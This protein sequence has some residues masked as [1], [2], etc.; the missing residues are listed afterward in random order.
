MVR[1]LGET[2]RMPQSAGLLIG[3]RP[4]TLPLPVLAAIR[5]C[6]ELACGAGLLKRRAGLAVDQA[7]G[8]AGMVE[9]LRG[10]IPQVLRRHDVSLLRADVSDSRLD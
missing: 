3:D 6:D 10:F 2:L 7:S 1:L 5:H 9:E 8:G 4:P